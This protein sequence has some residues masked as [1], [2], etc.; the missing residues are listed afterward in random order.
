MNTNDIGLNLCC[1]R[2]V[3]GAETDQPQPN[4]NHPHHRHRHG[5][6]DHQYIESAIG[7]LSA[8]AAVLITLSG[9]P[10][11]AREISRSP[12]IYRYWWRWWWAC[13]W[14]WRRSARHNKKA[15]KLPK[16][17]KTGEEHNLD[18]S[19]QSKLWKTNKL[20]V[21]IIQKSWFWQQLLGHSHNHRHTG[22]SSTWCRGHSKRCDQHQ[23]LARSIT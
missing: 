7:K 10:N 8:A 20:F 1:R 12:N 19:N 6:T 3:C 21:F 18:I 4:T 14:D 2:D 23:S 11:S 13:G 9:G 15:H 17:G 5:R 22:P 16:H